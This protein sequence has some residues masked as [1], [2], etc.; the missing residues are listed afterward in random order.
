MR[1]DEQHKYIPKQQQN[2]KL[3]E[4]NASQL[5]QPL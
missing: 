5:Q 2:G 1:Q 3:Q 4:K